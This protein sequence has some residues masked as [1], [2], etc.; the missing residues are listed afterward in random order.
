MYEEDLALNNQQWLISHITRPNQIKPNL[1]Y[2]IY[3]HKE[4][5][6]LDNL[7]WLIWHETQPNKII[8]M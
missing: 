1:I 4:D 2:L 3:M 5:L 6:T 8:Y 7:Q